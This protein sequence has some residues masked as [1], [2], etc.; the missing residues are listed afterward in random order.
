[1]KRNDYLEQAPNSGSFPEA[2]SLNRFRTNPGLGF[3][4]MIHLHAQLQVKRNDSAEAEISKGA[5][6]RLQGGEGGGV[7]TLGLEASFRSGLC[8]DT[9]DPCTWHSGCPRALFLVP[10]CL[11]PT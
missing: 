6:D 4:R 1:M 5:G 3:A 8:S 11:V 7:G 9:A 2:L 10:L